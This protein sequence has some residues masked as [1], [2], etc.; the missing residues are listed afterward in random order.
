MGQYPPSYESDPYPTSAQGA[1]PTGPGASPHSG[2]PPYG[3]GPARP[4][5]PPYGVGPTGPGASAYGGA[6]PYAPAPMLVLPPTPEQAAEKSLRTARGL[7][8]GA[9]ITGLISVIIQGIAPLGILLPLGASDSWSVEDVLI[10]LMAALL[11]I[12]L[13]PLIV[14]VIWATC[15]GLSLAACIVANTRRS[16]PL[17]ARWAGIGG[18]TGGVLTASIF[19]GAPL[20]IIILTAAN[21]GAT[22]DSGPAAATAAILVAVVLFFV[23][24]V[25]IS[26]LRTLGSGVGPGAAAPGQPGFTPAPPGPHRY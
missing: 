25:L 4:G 24:V 14:I 20:T 18:V 1:G 21:E 15:F 5:T 22:G 26:K 11:S 12:M 23:H 8:M 7:G 19:Q 9:A 6:P 16:T 13:V 3:V 2:A 17:P 10:W